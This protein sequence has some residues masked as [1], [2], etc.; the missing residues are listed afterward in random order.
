[1]TGEVW[2]KMGPADAIKIVG[3]QLP[4]YPNYDGA[5]PGVSVL[6]STIKGN[7]G[8]KRWFYPCNSYRQFKKDM[9]MSNRRRESEK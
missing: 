5:L 2:K 1:M 6:F 3:V 4:G 9:K 8:R 7:W